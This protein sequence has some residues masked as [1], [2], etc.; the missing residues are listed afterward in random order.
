MI[1]TVCFGLMSTDP[2]LMAKT[3]DIASSPVDTVNATASLRR[4]AKFTTSD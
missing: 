4:K 2:K 1:I 3:A